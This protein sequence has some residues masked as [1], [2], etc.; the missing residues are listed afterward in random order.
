MRDL[1]NHDKIKKN[2]LLLLSFLLIV[3]SLSFNSIDAKAAMCEKDRKCL[4]APTS[5]VTDKEF[6]NILK[7]VKTT[8]D[9]KELAKT[10]AINQLN[11]KD[12]VINKVENGR[13]T[14]ASVGFIFGKK[15]SADNLVY[16]EFIYDFNNQSIYT[17]K[18]LYGKLQESGHINIK[19]VIND[20][21]S[22]TMNINENGD[23]IGSD[24]Q[25]LT[26]DEFYK[27]AVQQMGGSKI[28]T[29]GWCEWVVGA[30][31]GTG[32]G[33]ACFALAAALG[34]TTGV[35]GLTLAGVCGLI[36]ALGCTGATL[37]ICG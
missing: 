33:I 30:L 29:F 8:A 10:T 19:M 12:V 4:E 24:G 15:T 21:V 5:N 20:D 28:A 9:Y 2:I 17:K 1:V 34:I 31:C 7:E 18:M 16:V 32:G 36:G 23:I 35:G 27:Q 37:T 25:V 3:M 26:Q 11:H 13:E 6:K 22:F 14:F